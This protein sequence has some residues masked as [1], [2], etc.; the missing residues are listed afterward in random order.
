MSSN[1]LVLAK[2][3]HCSA[4]SPLYRRRGEDCHC[5][6]RDPKWG[7]V[8]RKRNTYHLG[9][10]VAGHIHHSPIRLCGIVTGSAWTP[11]GGILPESKVL[12]IR[13]PPESI[14]VQGIVDGHWPFWSGHRDLV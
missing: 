2:T 5:R 4:I 11:Q 8:N 1:V 6:I 13:L 14:V 7:S 12:D 10:E 9:L 3:S